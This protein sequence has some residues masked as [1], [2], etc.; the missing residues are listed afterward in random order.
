MVKSGIGALARIQDVVYCKFD[1]VEVSRPRLV[2]RNFTER[3]HWLDQVNGA[4]R[5]FNELKRV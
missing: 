1:R 3:T 2:I 4:H 5:D